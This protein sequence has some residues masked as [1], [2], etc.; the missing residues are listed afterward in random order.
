MNLKDY[1]FIEFIEAIDSVFGRSAM[2]LI[3]VII[4]SYFAILIGSLGEEGLIGSWA[5]IPG[6]LTASIFYSLGIILLP[7]IIFFAIY[8]VRTEASF[9]LL[10]LPVIMSFY[11][12]YDTTYYIYNESMIAEFNDMVEEM[13]EEMEEE[14]QRQS[15][16][17][18]SN[19]T[20]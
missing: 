17:Q 20:K 8:F 19:D 5:A 1:P 16:A 18:Q 2:T 9:W 12:S 15:E 11:L 6:T 4:A 7:G 3:V 13:V 14:A 10:L